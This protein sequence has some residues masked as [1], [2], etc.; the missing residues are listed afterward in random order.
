MGRKKKEKSI[1]DVE[2]E[3]LGNPEVTGEEEEK[4]GADDEEEGELKGI[5]KT[6]LDKQAHKCIEIFEDLQAVSDSLTE[7]KNNLLP[8]MKEAGKESLF[9]KD[10][11][12]NGFE[13]RITTGIEK[14]SIRSKKEEM[15]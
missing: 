9:L 2:K 14:I 5:G 12:G 7:E 6:A 4:A 15:I 11:K 3:E 13:V 1:K 10:K 8:L